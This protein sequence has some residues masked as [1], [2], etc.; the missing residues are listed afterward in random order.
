MSFFESFGTWYDAVFRG[1]WSCKKNGSKSMILQ[2]AGVAL[3][4]FGNYFHIRVRCYFSKVTLVCITLLLKTFGVMGEDLRGCVFGNLRRCWEI[5][6]WVW[7]FLKWGSGRIGDRYYVKDNGDWVFVWKS[8]IGGLELE[9]EK[10]LRG[11]NGQKAATVR[12]VPWAKMATVLM[13]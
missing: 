4:R 9:M 13:M 1:L 3:G 5:K 2:G 11:R 8:E 10:D 6:L 12:R 7:Y